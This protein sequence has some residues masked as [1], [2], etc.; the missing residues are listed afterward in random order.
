MRWPPLGRRRD[1]D[2]PRTV[3]VSSKRLIELQRGALRAAELDAELSVRRVEQADLERRARAEALV[4]SAT[5]TG[6]VRASH[7]LLRA[8]LEDLPYSD[9]LSL[10]EPAFR[11]LLESRLWDARL[12]EAITTTDT[13]ESR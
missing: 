8:L 2:A 3:R 5:A 7:P 6:P 9:D 13:Q 10:H 12:G 4:S 11:A 1:P